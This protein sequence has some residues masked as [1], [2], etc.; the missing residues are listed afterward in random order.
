[1]TVPKEE[2]RNLQRL[3]SILQR[4][5]GRGLSR[6][7]EVDLRE[8]PRLYRFASSLHARLET[9]GDDPGTLTTTRDLIRRS[10]ALLYRGATAERRS[11]WAR[12]YALF[13]VDAPRTLRSEW[14]MLVFMLVFFY[15]LALFAYVAVSQN[16]E[17]AYTLFDPGIVQAEIA[18]LQATAEGEPFVGN[19]S[20]GMGE[21][22]RTAGLI[23][24]HN[25]GVSLLFFAA[26]LVPPFFLF[27]LASNA[28]MLG[29]YIGVAA[30]WDQGTAISSILWCHGT[31]EL[32]AIILAGMAGLV[33]VRAWIAPGPWSRN[34][35]LRLEAG[36]GVHVLAPMFPM[37]IVAGLIEGFVS[38]HAPTPV[39]LAVAA[40]TGLALLAW[41]FL[42]GTESGT[43][44]PP[45]AVRSQDDLLHNG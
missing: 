35:A 18:Q 32:Q 6:L 40:V 8:F 24:A 12:M 3:R 45:S 10:H 42:A 19:F 22:P 38:P 9:R 14:R 43:N 44:P 13:M 4:C 5:R 11:P 20:F 39:R 27:L 1:M 15:G 17:L 26:G 28:L 30:H 21:S 23:M 41:L 37:L 25:I 33:L 36:R 7:S 16:L 29:T 31:L 34:H 2:H